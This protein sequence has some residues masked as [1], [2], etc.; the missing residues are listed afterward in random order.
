MASNKLVDKLA[1]NLKGLV[2][3]VSGNIPGL[4]HGNSS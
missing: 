3:G 2:I 1:D 4:L